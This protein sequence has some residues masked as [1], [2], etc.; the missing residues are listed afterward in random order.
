M[1]QNVKHNDSNNNSVN[2]TDNS[3]GYQECL[4]RK[5]GT[6]KEVP[7]KK[8]KEEIFAKPSP[9]K[10]APSADTMGIETPMEPDYMRLPKG[11]NLGNLAREKFAGIVMADLYDRYEIQ[12]YCRLFEHFSYF[13]IY[14]FEDDTWVPA[15]EHAFKEVIRFRT[16]PSVLMQLARRA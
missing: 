8:A 14:K 9:S 5:T 2:Q 16:P 13:P 10:P 1:S 11:F 4:K 12:I 15:H 7:A 6:A 3:S